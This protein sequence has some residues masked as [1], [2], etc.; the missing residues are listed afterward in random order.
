MPR[1]AKLSPTSYAI[2]GLLARQARSAYELN[3]M[4]QGS[5]IRVFWPRAESHVYS[6]PKKL[7]AQELVSEHKEKVDGRN[8]TIYTIT[9]TGHTVLEHWLRDDGN[10]DLRTTS[11]LMLK[12]LLASEGLP[13]DARNVLEKSRTASHDDIQEAIA[14]IDNILQNPGYGV[15]GMPW[16]G[17]AINLMADLLIARYHWSEY[18]LQASTGCSND[19]DQQIEVG[20]QAYRLALEKMRKAIEDDA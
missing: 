16:N 7:L 14:G 19:P 11:E 9:S 18:A 6:E 1:A 13:E 2:L 17:I 8:R 3:G 12:L 10:T 20:R 4:M 15:E 5:L